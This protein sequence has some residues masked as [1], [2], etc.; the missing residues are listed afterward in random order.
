MLATVVKNVEL[1]KQNPEQEIYVTIGF[2]QET[3]S[4]YLPRLRKAVELIRAYA[5][6]NKLPIVFNNDVTKR[7]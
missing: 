5:E 4:T 6:E 3:A 7:L 2:H 1:W